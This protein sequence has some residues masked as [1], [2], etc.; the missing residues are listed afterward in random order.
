MAVQFGNTW[1]G[2]QWLNAFTHIDF[3]NRLPRGRTYARNGSV[4]SISFENQA[5]Y[6]KV[7]GSQRTPYKVNIHVKKFSSTEKKTILETVTGNPTFLA[8]LLSRELP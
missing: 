7:Q 5:I 2:K 8:K 4:K 6:G 1:W 3:S